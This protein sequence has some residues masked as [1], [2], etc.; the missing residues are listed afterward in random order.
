MNKLNFI[1]EFLLKYES[2]DEEQFKAAMED[3]NP[4]LEKIA[5]IVSERKKKSEEEN[6]TAHENNEKARRE[7]E[8]AERLQREKEAFTNQNFATDDFLNNIFAVPP[9]E[10]TSTEKTSENENNEDNEIE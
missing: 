6:K 5:E 10:D 7:K 1:A 8:E 9:K 2:M 3:E 4:T